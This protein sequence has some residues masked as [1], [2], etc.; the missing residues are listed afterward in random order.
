MAEQPEALRLADWLDD[1][2]CDLQTPRE[3]AA[4][5]RRLHEENGA[6]RKA[7]AAV[8]QALATDNPNRDDWPEMIVGQQ[9]RIAAL[10]KALGVAVEFLEDLAED[11]RP[12]TMGRRDIDEAA[13]AARQTLGGE[14]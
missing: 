6:H 14:A 5:L 7:Q 11:Y 12:G 10:E 4:E 1:D 8:Y 3:A 9:A 13:A 2:A